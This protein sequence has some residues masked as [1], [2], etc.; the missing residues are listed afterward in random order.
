[1]KPLNPFTYLKNNP[2]KMLPVFLSVAIGVLL[3]YIFSLFRILSLAPW[4]FGNH[5]ITPDS[6]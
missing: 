4:N 2:K 1:M 6:V 3:V 5:R